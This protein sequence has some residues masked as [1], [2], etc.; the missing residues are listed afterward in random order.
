MTNS[1]ITRLL[2]D[3]KDIS[4]TKLLPHRFAGQMT[5]FDDDYATGNTLAEGLKASRSKFKNI[6]GLDVEKLN[7]IL[8]DPLQPTMAIGIPN[9][10]STLEAM[11]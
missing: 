2:K 10:F 7:E 3:T 4:D 11:L 1:K 5:R 8:K 6:F 9:F